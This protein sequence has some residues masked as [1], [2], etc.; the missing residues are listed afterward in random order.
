MV[1]SKP[2]FNTT[3]VPATR[4]L[5]T[6]NDDAQADLTTFSRAV[7]RALSKNQTIRLTRPLTFYEVHGCVRGVRHYRVIE[8]L[9][10]ATIRPA[11]D[12]KSA[13]VRLSGDV[14]FTV[15]VSRPSKMSDGVT[16]SIASSESLRSMPIFA[17][18]ELMMRA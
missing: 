7:M 18:S 1:P 3:N 6:L 12:G 14:Q 4:Q 8:D 9:H 10:G 15:N 17:E 16:L 5:V 2:R 13:V 11:A